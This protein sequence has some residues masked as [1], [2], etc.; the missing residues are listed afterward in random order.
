MP[1]RS[2]RREM[3][4]ELD[5]MVRLLAIYDEENTEQFQELLDMY[6]HLSSTWYF[7]EREVIPKSCYMMDIIWEYKDKEFKQIARMSKLSF[8]NLFSLIENHELF[9]NESI[10]I[11]K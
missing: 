4:Y 3:L 5:N 6:A 11:L 8:I 2:D 10:V 9:K 1:K 7:S